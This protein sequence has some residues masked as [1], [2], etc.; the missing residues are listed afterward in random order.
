MSD[1][2]SKVTAVHCN[3]CGRNT[4]H[5]VLHEEDCSVTQEIGPHI[6]VTAYEFNRLLIC[7]GCRAVSLERITGHSEDW[8]PE[9][10]QPN[11]LN[12][13]YPPRTYRP[14]PRWV[15]EPTIP[16]YARSSLAEIYIAVQNDL[17][18]LAG[19]G[20]RALLESLMIKTVGDQGTFVANL[21][22]FVS[23]G[24][25]SRGQKEMFESTL[26]LGHAAIHRGFVPT[27]EALVACLDATEHVVQSLYVF[28]SQ[29]AALRKAIPK[30]K[31]TGKLLKK[32][33][34]KSSQE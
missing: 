10:G 28:P 6:S 3:Q 4:E 14:T 5:R 33:V 11:Y 32:T 24:H 25:V 18:S 13:Y 19:M 21:T 23:A 30:R 17:R 20:I 31:K 15:D 26:E 12:Q 34:S 2:E 27:A 16:A 1:S 8:D 7:A 22:A 9:T 29:S